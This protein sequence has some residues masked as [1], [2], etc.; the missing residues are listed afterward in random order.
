PKRIRR[1]CPVILQQVSQKGRR[2]PNGPTLT[3]AWPIAATW[4]ITSPSR[5]SDFQHPLSPD[6]RGRA[7]RNRQGAGG[8]RRSTRSG[9]SADVNVVLIGEHLAVA[10]TQAAEP[11]MNDRGMEAL[12]C[13][14]VGNSSSFAVP[15]N[16][17]PAIRSIKSRPNPGWAGDLTVGPSLS[18]Q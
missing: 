9:G 3:N 17:S 12:Q 5:R 1:G 10:A 8:Q 14:P 7:C 13:A 15:P 6:Q 18:R 16:M 2:N 4:A 11:T